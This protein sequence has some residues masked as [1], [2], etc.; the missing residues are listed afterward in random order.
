MHTQFVNRIKRMSGTVT[1][2]IANIKT[3]INPKTNPAEAHTHAR[4]LYGNESQ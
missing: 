4:I 3:G 2:E 1:V